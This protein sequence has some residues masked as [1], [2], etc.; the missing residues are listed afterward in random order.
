MLKPWSVLF[1]LFAFPLSPLLAQGAS[2]SKSSSS[3]AHHSDEAFVIEQYSSKQQFE[4]D[5]T[6]SEE[7]SWRVRI[8]I[9]QEESEA[10]R[11]ALDRNARA[12]KSLCR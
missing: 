1:L 12:R 2:S 10:E 5:G 11:G 6:Y 8:Q 4:N 9:T 7:N 3:K